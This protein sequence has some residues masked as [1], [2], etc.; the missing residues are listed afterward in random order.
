MPR[1]TSPF[2]T[3]EAVPARARPDA[4]SWMN[5]IAK[6]E[7]PLSACRLA[8]LSVPG[9]PIRGILLGDLTTHRLAASRPFLT[10]KESPRRGLREATDA[11]SSHDPCADVELFNHHLFQRRSDPF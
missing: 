10:V 9:Y 11:E 3:N 4:M 7:I 2:Q 6:Q 8:R 1:N 5:A